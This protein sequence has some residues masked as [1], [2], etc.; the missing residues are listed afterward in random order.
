METYNERVKFR[1]FQM[2]CCGQLLCW[3]NS[4][5]PNYCPECGKLIYMEMRHRE[6]LAESETWLKITKGKITPV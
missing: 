3:L 1:L 5:L 6:T 2:P 4:R